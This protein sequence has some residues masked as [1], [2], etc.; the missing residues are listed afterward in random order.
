MI[1]SRYRYRPVTVPLQFLGLVKHRYL[2][3]T[4][5]LPYR[6]LTVTDRYGPLLGI[7]LEPLIILKKF[8][9]IYIFN[10]K[11]KYFKINFYCKLIKI[12]N[13]K[14]K[15][16]LFC[17]VTKFLLPKLFLFFSKNGE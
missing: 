9:C 10:I 1:S 5:P 4:L 17:D 8:Q 2:T 16:T 13:Q 6:Y 12:R 11:I 7:F 3:V 14:L 15:Q